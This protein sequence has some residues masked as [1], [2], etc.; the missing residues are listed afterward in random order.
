MMKHGYTEEF[1]ITAY[2][3]T[4]NIAVDL[5]GSLNMC[6]VVSPRFGVQFKDLPKLAEN[7]DPNP[8]VWFHCPDNVSW[9]HRP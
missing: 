2:Y 3:L 8:P 9:H 4:G 7:S 1:E 5:M 6:G